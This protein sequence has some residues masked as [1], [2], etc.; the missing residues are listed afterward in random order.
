MTLAATI[1]GYVILGFIG[2]MILTG[3]G[4]LIIGFI[5]MSSYK[6]LKFFKW[7]PSSHITLTEEIMD[8]KIY[9][10]AILPLGKKFALCLMK[11]EK[12]KDKSDN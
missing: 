10:T 6:I 8:K 11:A 12:E 2:L 4:I 9:V 3:I 7:Q 5:D 1:I